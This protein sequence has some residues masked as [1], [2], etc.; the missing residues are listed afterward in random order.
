[1]GVET[2]M[3]TPHVTDWRWLGFC[4]G[5]RSFWYKNFRK[6]RQDKTKSWV[7][8]FQKIVSVVKEKVKEVEKKLNK[9]KDKDK[10]PQESKA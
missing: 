4:E 9:K 2:L 6:I 7:S 3:L 10:E 8:S 1:M 5:E